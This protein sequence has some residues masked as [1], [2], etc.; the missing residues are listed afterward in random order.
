MNIFELPILSVIVFLPL[1]GTLIVSACR[2]RAHI[3]SASLITAF[4][5]FILTLVPVFLYRSDIPGFQFVEYAPWIST[6]GISYHVGID[7]LSLFLLP[8]TSF[9][10]IMAIL[11]SWN[12][13]ATKENLYYG[14]FLILETSMLGVFVAIDTVLFYVFWEAMLIPMFLIIGIWGGTNRRYAS[15]KFLI[16]TMVGS[17]FMLVALIVMAILN[18]NAG[19]GLSFD[20]TSWLLL[21]IPHRFQ[22]WLFLAFFVAFAIKVP[23]F[24]FHT[25]LP[26]AHVEAPTAGSV[27]L[28]GIL[29]KMGVYGMLRF[30]YPLFPAAIQMFTPWIIGLGMIGVIYGAFLAFAQ[31]DMK[32]LIAY[33]SI[34]HMGLIIVGIFALNMAGVTGGIIQ[35]V[36]HGL[37]TGALFILVGALY[38]RKGTRDLDKLGGLAGRVP[39]LATF[40]MIIL[41]SSIGLPGLNGFVGEILL[42][43]G[44]FEFTWWVGALGATT[45]IM[46]AVY[47]LRMYQR[48]MFETERSQS[49]TPISDFSLR[50]KF[51]MTPIVL[52]VFFIG[53]FPSFFLDRIDASAGRLLSQLHKPMVVAAD[54]V[55]THYPNTEG[56]EYELLC[57]KR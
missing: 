1:A 47:M 48:A 34:S 22:G 5:S 26:D 3:Q 14:L 38:E 56:D 36:N 13:I 43:L 44:A 25:W 41:L 40:F 21:N 11:V 53:I 4:A 20:L 18:Q 2:K 54:T 57:S 31:T 46:S 37:S 24:P 12:R 8:L 33:S 27:V 32:K 9:L 15:I 29:L 49:E 39:V 17:V 23:L 16:Y 35:M 19:A 52:L 6:L 50:E 30:C 10:T 7:G 55:K 45:V 42:L 28:A 51:I